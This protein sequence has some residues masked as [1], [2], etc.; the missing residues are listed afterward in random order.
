MPTDM[1]RQNVVA[2]WGL[3]AAG[4][5]LIVL[6]FMRCGLGELGW[7]VFAPFPAFLH[8]HSTLRQHLAVLAVLVGAW[9]LAVSKI[10]TSEIP[11]APVPMFA[12]PIAFSTFAI[13]TL[14]SLA[15]RRLGTRWRCI[16]AGA[17]S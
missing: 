5:A 16:F 3:L 8:A 9:L 6:T 14:A 2:V 17:V 11:W 10:A 4:A 12:I 13:L 15:H 1:S 7:I